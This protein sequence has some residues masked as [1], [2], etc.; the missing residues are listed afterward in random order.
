MADELGVIDEI[1]TCQAPASPA[2]VIYPVEKAA[3]ALTRVLCA[4][5]AKI[6]SDSSDE[7]DALMAEYAP[8]LSAHQDKIMLNPAY[9]ER[10]KQ[11][12]QNDN[13][14]EQVQHWVAETLK[15][16]RICGAELSAEKQHRLREI[17]EQLAVNETKWDQN[18]V[19]ERN[20]SAVLVSDEDELAGLDQD[21]KD[22]LAQAASQAGLSGWLI[23][24]INTT[25][26]PILADLDNRN[27]RK[28][29]FQAAT[30]RGSHGKFDMRQLIIETARLRAEKAAL[31]GFDNY[32]ELAAYQGT[33]GSVE[34]INQVLYPMR[35]QV[36]EIARKEAERL[37]ASFGSDFSPW[38]WAYVAARERTKFAVSDEQIRPYL[39]FENVVYDGIFAEANILYG[40][41]FHQITA[42]TYVDD[43]I[44]F[45][46]L[47]AD[48]KLLGG[49]I[50]DPYARPTKQGGAWMSELITQNQLLE[51]LPIVTLN[52]NYP[53]PSPGAPT[54]L[55]WDEV[56]TL[57][58]EFGHCL[59]GLF[60]D[61][62][63][64]SMAGSNTP[65]DYVEFPS[66][67][68]E[69]W[70]LDEG[71]ITRYAK[72]WQTNEPIPSQMLTKLKVATKFNQGFEDYEM[73]AAIVLD[74]AWHTASLDELPSEP[75]EVADF[76]ARALARAGLASE[77]I[78]PRYSSTYF[79]H[80]WSGGYSG[81]YYGYL[82]SEL[83]DADACAWFSENGGMTRENG[84]KFRREI[85]AKGFSEPLI[86]SYR[87][88]R[89]KPED[90][91]YLLARHGAKPANVLAS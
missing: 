47:E 7:M 35:D 39:K 31:L 40:I 5:E 3:D 46:V 64:P 45:E 4:F 2:N 30:C 13:L 12:A 86:P 71:L 42:P 33:A 8:R 26:Q 62:L 24:M 32:A 27:L 70:A 83:L 29:I 56:I 54:L 67:V 41:S 91:R 53:K 59:N 20:A 10:V 17:N 81:A 21:S 75:N 88:F 6:S 18:V 23:E 63:L 79:S 73:L 60:S 9:Y 38:D 77:L 52:C 74:Q 90:V 84:E 69:Y 36:V 76:Q 58:H 25:G 51:A 11:L 85:L 66:Q 43:A 28:R 65:P 1:T 87:A 89:G 68:N 19:A 14:E 78:P 48:G 49:L 80:I 37:R 50:V 16:F 61:C 15:D 57:F 34:A 72:H 55:S 82:W 22:R 44:A